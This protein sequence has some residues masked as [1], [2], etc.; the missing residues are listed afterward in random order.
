MAPKVERMSWLAH[1]WYL[2]E[3]WTGLYML[4]PW[5]K[6]FFSACPTSAP[7]AGGGAVVRH[8]TRVSTLLRCGIVA[9]AHER[10]Y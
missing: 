6:F 2:Y 5:E 4:D 8:P 1:K 9:H 10:T 7:R 3:L